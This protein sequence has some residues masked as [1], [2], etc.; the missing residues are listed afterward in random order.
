MWNQHVYSGSMPKKDEEYR[1]RLDKQLKSE[2]IDLCRKRDIPAAQVLRE[3]MRNFVRE[4]READQQ[5]LFQ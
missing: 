4:N 3:L 1:I 5:Q 2:F